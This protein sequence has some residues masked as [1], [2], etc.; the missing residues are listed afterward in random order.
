MR[1]VIDNRGV[2]TSNPEEATSLTISG[3][4]T[5]VGS[6]S[7]LFATGG[8][9]QPT[10]SY[11]DAGDAASILAASNAITVGSTGSNAYRGGVVRTDTV[12]TGTAFTASSLV[13]FYE[14]AV[15]GST[16]TLSSTDAV[17]TQ[18]EFT[19]LASLALPNF[20][21]TPNGGKFITALGSIMALS[22]NVTNQGFWK[23]VKKQS[24]GNWL[25]AGIE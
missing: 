12:V 15:S 11:I 23:R 10:L 1:I 16:C 7:Q 25:V 17:G 13:N 22:V 24:D 3:S 9:Q 18:Y 2:I 8:A 4:I 5:L 6:G 20:T 19:A 21:L 14:I